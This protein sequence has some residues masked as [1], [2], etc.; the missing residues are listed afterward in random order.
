MC[1]TCGC[2]KKA[3]LENLKAAF[4]GESNASAKYAIYAEAAAEQGYL[5]VA[6]LFRAASRAETIHAGRHAAVIKA[7]GSDVTAEIGTYTGKSI[8]EMLQDAVAGETEE[9]TH[10]YPGFIQ[11]AD[12]RGFTDAVKSF[13]GAMKAEVVH[14]GLYKEA[15]ENLDGWKESRTFAVCPV[16]GWTEV[17]IPT[18]RCPI[19]NLPAEKFEI[20]K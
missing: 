8:T 11:E 6:S 5:G 7:W 17:G 16:C 18:E 10:M 9:F 12:T 13:T 15:L 4:N 1:E 3:T 2:A 14:A 20:F 19:C